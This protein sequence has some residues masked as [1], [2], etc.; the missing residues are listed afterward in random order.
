MVHGENSHPWKFD[1]WSRIL[2]GQSV[3]DEGPLAFRHS[4]PQFGTVCY[5]AGKLTYTYILLMFER[6]H[7]TELYRCAFHRW[8][9]WLFR[10]CDFSL[11]E[12]LQSRT[13]LID[14]IIIKATGIWRWTG[15]DQLEVWIQRRVY[16]CWSFIKAVRKHYHCYVTESAGIWVKFLPH[17]RNN[18]RRGNCQKT[19]RNYYFYY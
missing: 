10:T 16:D 7:R 2:I 14:L 17:I 5:Y 19:F 9:S 1:D 15:F 6:H 18:Q 13:G 8:L 3:V 11:W 12:W 4:S